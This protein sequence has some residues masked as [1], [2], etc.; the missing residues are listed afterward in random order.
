MKPESLLGRHLTAQDAADYLDHQLGP[1]RMSEVEAHLATPC[2]DCRE[3]LRS[4][5]ELTGRMRADRSESVPDALHRRAIELFVPRPAPSAQGPRLIAVARL[6]F[7]SW[8]QPLPAAVRRAVGEARRLRWWL[9]QGTLE[10]ELEPD[11]DGALTLRGRLHAPDPA[12]QRI[13]ARALS[14]A[15]VAWPDASGAF[16]FPRLPAADLDLRVVGPDGIDRVPTVRP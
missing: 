10:I 3:R 11:A 1:R 7:D 5:A 6:L 16:A 8:A 9:S 13:E 12:L 4:L 2:G 15:F 14:E